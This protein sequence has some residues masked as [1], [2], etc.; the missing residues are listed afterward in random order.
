MP[1]YSSQLWEEGMNVKSFKLV[2]GGVFQEEEVT[3]LLMAPGEYPGCS[4]TRNLHDNLSD[5]RAQVAA[6]QK[7]RAKL[8]TTMTASHAHAF[9]L[10]V[11]SG[12]SAGEGTD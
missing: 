3:A 9:K 11:P 10:P 6:N 1:P 7:V 12:Y 8:F 4:G 5:L 2:E